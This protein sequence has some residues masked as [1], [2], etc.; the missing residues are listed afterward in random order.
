MNL[1][2]RETRVNCSKVYV[3]SFMRKR[4]AKQKLG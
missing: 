1:G 2:P 4:A 3:L